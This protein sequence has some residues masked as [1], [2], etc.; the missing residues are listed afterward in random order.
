MENSFLASKRLASKN[1]ISSMYLPILIPTSSEKRFFNKLSEEK[2]ACATS[3]MVRF[4]DTNTSIWLAEGERYTNVSKM[5]VTIPGVDVAGGLSVTRWS[6]SGWKPTVYAYETKYVEIDYHYEPSADSPGEG[7]QMTFE[8]QYLGK[9]GVY[10]NS[11]SNYTNAVFPAKDTKKR[12]RIPSVLICQI[13]QKLQTAQGLP[14]FPQAV[15]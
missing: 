12:D 2:T 4:E 14:R 9:S 13:S 8:V 15:I 11:G 1:T 3:E 10:G 6:I 7:S 5:T